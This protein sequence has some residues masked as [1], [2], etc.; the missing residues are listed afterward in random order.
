MTV[1]HLAVVESSALLP[2]AP[3]SSR[4]PAVHQVSR[5]ILLAEDD[6]EMRALVARA[7]RLDGY[8]VIEV[9][10]GGR[11]LIRLASFYAPAH[12]REAF[13]LLISDIRM[14][15]CSG[16]QILERLRLAH[17]KMPAILMTASGDE[18]MERQAMGLG[19]VLFSKPFDVDD[20]RVAVMRLLRPRP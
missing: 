5:R 12:Q 8:E 1:E 18:R 7:L 6:G 13:D 2:A 11:T 14:P 4:S 10:D 15:V 17:W 16:L 20:L 9:D 19:A 3:R